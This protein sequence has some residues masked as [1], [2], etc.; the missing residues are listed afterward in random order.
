MTV[1]EILGVYGTTYK[2]AK[3]TGLSYANV[4]NW[5][6]LGYIPMSTQKKIQLI[7]EGRLLA[8]VNKNNE[9]D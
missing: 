8:D 1:D 7:T 9:Q 3:Q 6:R 5:Q 4:K 2:F